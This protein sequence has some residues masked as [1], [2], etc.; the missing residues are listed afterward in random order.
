MKLNRAYITTSKKSKKFKLIDQFLL[1]IEMILDLCC[2]SIFYI[3]NIFDNF[4]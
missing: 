2:N 1:I 4:Y 3:K